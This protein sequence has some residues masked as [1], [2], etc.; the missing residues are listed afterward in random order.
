MDI[1][2]GVAYNSCKAKIMSDDA[3]YTEIPAALAKVFEELRPLEPIFHNPRFGATIEAFADRM[4][5]DFWEVG[6]SGRRYSRAFILELARN[7]PEIWV[8]AETAGWEAS[9][10]GLRELAPAT[11]LLTYTLNQKGRLS[12]RATTW[13]QTSEG[14]KVL[15]HQGTEI[16][17]L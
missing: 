3:F 11:Y 9:G 10:F 8:D 4:T 17:E 12:R 2:S 5:P 1:R 15:Y 16:K 7:Q 6:A 14:W 13:K